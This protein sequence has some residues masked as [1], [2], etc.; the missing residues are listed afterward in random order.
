MFEKEASKYAGREQI[1][2]QKIPIL[3]SLWNDALHFCAVHPSQIKKAL[4]ESGCTTEFDLEFFEVDP[5]LL[6]PENTVVYLYGHNKEDDKFKEENFAKYNPNDIARYSVMPD[7]TKEYYR[8][9]FEQN[10]NP[11][12]FHRVPHILFKGSLDISGIKK[13]PSS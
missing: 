10:Q 1:M 5:N 11:L 9:T 7:E 4:L 12:L 2:Q 3:D 13:R 8:K 6:N